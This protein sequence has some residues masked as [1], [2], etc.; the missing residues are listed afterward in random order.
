[1]K[2]LHTLLLLMLVATTSL[3]ANP[4]TAPKSDA[5]VVGHVL[6]AAT[7]EHLS[8][9]TIAVKGTTIGVV[10]D[11]S[12]H[13]ALRNVPVG[14]HTILASSVGYESVEKVI[15]V[16][17]NTTQEC[18]FSLEEALL[19]MDEVVVSASRNEVSRLESAS[20]VNIASVKLFETTAS[21]NMAETMSFQPGLR[22]ENS[23]SNCGAAQ[24]RINGLEGHYSQMLLDSRPI[25]S[26]LSG[27]YGL[28]QLPVAMIERV[29][30]VR[31]G[32]SALFGSSAIGGVVNIITKEPLSNSMTVSHTAQSFEGGGYD[33]NT[34]LN[35]SFV[36]SDF[37]TGVYLFGMIRDKDAYDRNDDGFS[38]T[39]LQESE[40][41]G[42]RGYH[43]LS[44]YSKLTAEYHH[45]SEYRRG[46]D[47][48][49]LVAHQ[50][51]LAEEIS[52]RIDGG[53]L[54]Y[55]Y[56]SP[57]YKHKFSVY[58][59]AQAINRDSY[60][61]GGYDTEAYGYTN[62]LT[63][64]AGAQYTYTFDNCLFMPAELTAGT[65]YT[66]NDL[67]D[68]ALAYD[69]DLE[70]T[71]HLYG[72]YAQNE[73][74]NEKLSV[75]IGGRVDKHN[76]MEDV[77]VSPRANVRYSP[78]PEVGIRASYSSGY[79]APQAFD[80]D[81]HIEGVAGTVEII[82]LADDLE[83]EYS[84][85]F[86]GSVDLYRSFGEWQANLLLEGFYTKLD[87]VF[88]LEQTSEEGA[89]PIVYERRNGEGATV[90][91]ITAELRLASSMGLDFQLGYTL[92]RSL[93]DVAEVWSDDL[94][95]QTTMFRTPNQYGYFTANYDITKAF[96]A[97]L[98]G[99][100]TGTMLVQHTT[101]EGDFEV[102]TPDFFD[103]GLRLSYLFKVSP[104]LSIE[105]NGGVKNIFDAYQSDIDT[106]A[107]KDA[108]YIYGPS[109]PR[110][111]FMGLKM[112]L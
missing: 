20:I 99:N 106:G 74:K 63:A 39:P 6:D 30:V 32:G 14:E 3:F 50:V 10:T 38:D 85:S 94:E 52:H 96:T 47:N 59:S 60:Y 13:F 103:M 110:T 45:I 69:R 16:K 89:A 17:A 46:G 36:S 57:N 2:Y 5:T 72:A 98:F 40:T 1:M 43:K 58:S 49:D 81:L 95:A 109:L 34:S 55:N 104:S 83:A 101:T 23:C 48:L 35:G 75:L 26:S 54:T 31:G 24:L 93:Y 11:A 53:G 4:T 66:Y 29:E 100:Y 77:I 61:G 18:N 42:F 19:Q 91:G 56:L 90:K 12:G 44:P 25:F 21:C 112:T 82:N 28:E 7:G 8:F 76:L 27:V 68:V 107:E 22:V 33:F 88:V 102:N 87:N 105:L 62:D 108:G 70:Q 84:H 64:V 80:E 67:H 111:Y 79:R 92:Q 73:W 9:I 86:S 41:L 37:K 97:S 71:T 78:L 15:S 65:E 51:E